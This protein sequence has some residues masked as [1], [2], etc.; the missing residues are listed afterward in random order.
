MVVVC[1]ISLIEIV[2]HD[3]SQTPP[4]RLF[5]W[6]GSHCRWRKVNGWLKRRHKRNLLNFSSQANLHCNITWLC[7]SLWKEEIILVLL[8]FMLFFILIIVNIVLTFIYFFHSNNYINFV[9]W[10][11][12]D[13][14][15][16][17][18]V[19]NMIK[20]FLFEVSKLFSKEITKLFNY[21]FIW[22][23]TASKSESFEFQP[24]FWQ[25]FEYYKNWLKMNFLLPYYY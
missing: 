25:N 23:Q 10:G 11:S 6:T 4:F 18:K 22:I 2:R 15:F 1:N 14:G 3:Y 8:L 19:A 24:V 17:T 16:Q 12:D 21:K 5:V 13:Q 20:M 7:I 9:A